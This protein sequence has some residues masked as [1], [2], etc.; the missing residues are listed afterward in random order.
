MAGC[1]GA[2][3]GT[4]TVGRVYV[5]KGGPAGVDTSAPYKVFQGNG[6]G[7]GAAIAAGDVNNDGYTDLVITAFQ[8]SV[9]GNAVGR[10]YVN[11]SSASGFVTAPS[12]IDGP[13]GANAY[14]GYAASSAGD[15]NGDGYTDIAI[16]S[17]HAAVSG[18][19]NTGIVDVYLGGST[20]L[21]V[22]SLPINGL[23]SPG[24]F[25]WTL[26]PGFD[27]TN[28][29]FSDV[30][31]GSIAA[32][33]YAGRVVLWEGAS[34]GLKGTYSRNWLAPDANDYLGSAVY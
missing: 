15:V 21:N 26:A 7:F 5:Y 9:G 10:A 25:G 29:G 4:T 11:L 18:N 34:S 2:T 32:G 30:V 27:M 14:F 31:I 16:G 24:Y 22:T 19:N 13:H 23:D 3:Q 20:G 1:S 12:P 6:G 33:S 28:D 17:P 8:E